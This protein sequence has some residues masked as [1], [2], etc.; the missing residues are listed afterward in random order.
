MDL[1]QNYDHLNADDEVH[2]AICK[3]IRMV[4][5]SLWF[6]T[7]AAGHTRAVEFD[8]SRHQN[9]ALATAGVGNDNRG[10]V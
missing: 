10:R 1:A 6:V 7:K 4:G 2:R 9:S 5:V 8:I 3:I